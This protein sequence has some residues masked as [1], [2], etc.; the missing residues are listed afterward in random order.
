[1]I[2]VRYPQ[3]QCNFNVPCLAK[4]KIV[5][6]DF[7]TYLQNFSSNSGKADIFNQRNHLEALD[8]KMFAIHSLKIRVPN[9]K[10]SLYSESKFLQK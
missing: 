7:N 6:L 10:F 2:V 1:M 9:V 4:V 5:I 8:S 3:A